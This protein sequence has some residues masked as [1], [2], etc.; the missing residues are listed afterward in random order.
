MWER[1]LAV[2]QY[3]DLLHPTFGIK[4]R[5]LAKSKYWVTFPV[6]FTACLR[7]TL[8]V[9]VG[10]CLRFLKLMT[11]VPNLVHFLSTKHRN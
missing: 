1:V 3:L 9:G 10:F 7:D 2:T 5:F 8:K 6:R 4:H 11:L